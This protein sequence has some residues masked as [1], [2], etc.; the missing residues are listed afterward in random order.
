MADFN[1]AIG[2]TLK[3]EGGYNDIKEDRGGATNFGI[4]LKFYRLNIDSNAT[5][6]VIKNL[7]QEEACKIYKKFFWD[8]NNFDLINSQQ[9]ANKLFDTCVNVGNV[10]GI[11][12]VQRICNIAVDGICGLL[13]IASINKENT[14]ELINKYMAMQEEFYLDL[15]KQRPSQEAFRKGWLKRANYKGV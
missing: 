4:S 8:I 7:T 5:N 6:E 14:D 3:N 15:I 11:K 10:Q 13:T 9:I 12:F 1:L 2:H